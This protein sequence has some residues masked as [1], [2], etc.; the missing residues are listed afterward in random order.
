MEEINLNLGS[1]S[2]NLNVSNSNDS[3]SIKININEISTAPPRKSVNFGPGAEMLMNPNKNKA[4]SPKADIKL[5]EL[6][7]LGDINII[8]LSSIIC[9]SKSFI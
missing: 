1:S 3:G 7:E 2:S 5:S 8:Y 9:I 4:T 6:N